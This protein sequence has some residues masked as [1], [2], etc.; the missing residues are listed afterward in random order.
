MATTSFSRTVGMS[1]K[2]GAQLVCLLQDW[3]LVVDKR[4]EECGPRSPL[5]LTR[6]PPDALRMTKQESAQAS[7]LSGRL[8]CTPLH[9]SNSLG[10]RRRDPMGSIWYVCWAVFALGSVSAWVA[11]L[12][13]ASW[14]KRRRFHPLAGAPRPFCKPVTREHLHS[15]TEADTTLLWE[16]R[17]RQETFV[18]KALFEFSMQELQ[19]AFPVLSADHC[20]ALLCS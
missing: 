19:S 20:R 15:S 14:W 4:P 3:F 6:C 13:T 10:G 1:G 2:E 9:A 18:T 11:V 7:R 17:I 16:E 5:A 8:R 12:V